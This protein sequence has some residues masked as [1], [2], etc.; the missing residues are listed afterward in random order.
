MAIMDL[1]ALGRRAGRETAKM[2]NFV[3][4]NIFKPLD[5]RV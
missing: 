2:S 1:L 4:S 3:G 5:K